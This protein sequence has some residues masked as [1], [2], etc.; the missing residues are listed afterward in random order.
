MK[1]NED[2]ILEWA[3]RLNPLEHADNPAELEVQ[4]ELY[5]TGI[6]NDPCPDVC[7]NC[8]G[9]L[10]RG[11]GFAGELIL[12]CNCEKGGFHWEDHEGA[13]RNVL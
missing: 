12:Y 2:E 8:K 7:P 1:R 4:R 3:D 5:R 13:I 11:S 10:Q 9:E 6:K